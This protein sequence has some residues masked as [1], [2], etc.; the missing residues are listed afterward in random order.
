MNRTTRPCRAGCSDDGCT[1]SYHLGLTTKDFV[2]LEFPTH[3]N[4]TLSEPP[5]VYVEGF[6]GA[7]YLDRPDEIDQY[8]AAWAEIR[9]VALS[10]RQTR[11]LVLTIAKEYEE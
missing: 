2:L 3:P 9:A 10:E 4:P 8:R 6:T 5:V 1:N 7:L 11:E